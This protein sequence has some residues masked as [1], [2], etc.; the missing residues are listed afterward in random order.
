VWEELRPSHE[1][2]RG[3]YEWL[4][5]HP[6]VLTGDSFF[7]LSAYGQSIEGLNMCGAGRIV[8]CVD[9]LGDVYA[10]PFLL[11]PEFSAGNVRQPGGFKK[12]WRESSLF[13]H[14]RDWQVGGSCQSCNA[15]GKCHGGCIAVKH[16]TGRPVD[17][18]DPDCVFQNDIAFPIPVK[19]VPLPAGTA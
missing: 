2:N 5:Q 12:L 6:D 13:A 7:H 19:A 4:L 9:P 10:C 11:D 3:L 15:Y 8:C 14:L 1:Q 18:P 16:F 17:A